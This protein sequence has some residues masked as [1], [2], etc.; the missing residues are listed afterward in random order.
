MICSA[1]V[2]GDNSEPSK[3]A[4]VKRAVSSAVEMKPPAAPMPDGSLLYEDIYSG[5]S[6]E[7]FIRAC[8]NTVNHGVVGVTK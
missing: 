1:A 2:T 8:D 7:F 5:Q 3:R 6:K 4:V